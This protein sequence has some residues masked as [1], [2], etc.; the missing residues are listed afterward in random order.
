MTTALKSI[1]PIPIHDSSHGIR[2]FTESQQDSL[3]REH[4]E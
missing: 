3:V 2:D 1:L 4:E